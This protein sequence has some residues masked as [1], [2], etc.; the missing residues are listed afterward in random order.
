MP[1]TLMVVLVSVLNKPRIGGGEPL[2]SP[3]P[4]ARTAVELRNWLRRT[5]VAVTLLLFHF[6]ATVA[7]SQP[8]SYLEASWF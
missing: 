2:K 3:Q 6:I 1:V 7:P 5:R 8:L 4:I